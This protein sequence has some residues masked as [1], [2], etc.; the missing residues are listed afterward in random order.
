MSIYIYCL[1]RAF[2]YTMHA[3]LAAKQRTLTMLTGT[4]CGTGLGTG[5]GTWTGTWTG[6]KAM[7][8]IRDMTTA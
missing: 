2:K 1:L 8:L 6:T 7:L 3:R 4:G 5:T